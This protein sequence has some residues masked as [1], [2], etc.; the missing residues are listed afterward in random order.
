MCCGN[1]DKIEIPDSPE[2]TFPPELGI[3]DAEIKGMNEFLEKFKAVFDPLLKAL[4]EV[5]NE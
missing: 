3:T 2:V 4:K 1:R 5:N